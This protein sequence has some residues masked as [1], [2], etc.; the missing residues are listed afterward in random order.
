MSKC[1][2]LPRAKQTARNLDRQLLRSAESKR[3][4]LNCGLRS[5]LLSREL[6][7]SNSLIEVLP[8]WIQIFEGLLRKV[9]T[10]CL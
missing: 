3:V 4:S 8:T 10:N 7:L 2:L 5:Y 1:S 9:K 6:V